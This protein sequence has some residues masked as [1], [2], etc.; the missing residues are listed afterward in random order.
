MK[1]LFIH[2]SCLYL[3]ASL[4]FG[5]ASQSN[6]QGGPRDVDPPQILSEKS[7]PNYQTQFNQRSI[8][9]QFNEFIKLQEPQNQIVVTPPL[10]YPPKLDII[11]K[12]LILRLH[13][14]EVLREETTY[15]IQL[16]KA[17]QDITESNTAENITWVFST[18]ATLDS[19]VLIGE[20][21]EYESDK[22]IAGALVMLYDQMAD[23]A[24]YLNKPLYFTY[25]D[26][27][28][29]YS[30][31][32]LKSG[33]YQM[34]ALKEEKP[35]Y[36]YDQPGE[37]IGFQANT[38]MVSEDS[39]SL[40]TIYM[41]QEVL[42]PKIQD[43]DSTQ[44]GTLV[45]RFDKEIEGTVVQFTDNPTQ[46]SFEAEGNQLTIWH[47][48]DTLLKTSVK[49]TQNN[50]KSDSL[51]ISSYP[52]ESTMR[53]KD[54][55]LSIPPSKKN[56]HPDSTA[57]IRFS[58]PIESIDVSKWEIMD[59][60]NNSNV[61][62]LQ[63]S[64]VIALDQSMRFF[65][66]P[67]LPSGEYSLQLRPGG[68]IDRFGMPNEQPIILV[69]SIMPLRDFV[70]ME[71]TLDSLDPEKNYMFRLLAENR[72]I[73]QWNSEGQSQ[74]IKTYPSIAIGKYQLEYWLDNN[75]NQRWDGGNYLKKKYPERKWT[76]PLEPL[77]P[78]WDSKQRLVIPSIQRILQD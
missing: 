3:F 78:D 38:I 29:K 28:G 60:K 69:F 8:T 22:P 57:L 43:V 58:A 55:S 37:W 36:R 68:V 54:P 72:V 23:S 51:R 32:H 40:P 44:K 27:L 39:A 45:V 77:R 33:I 9:L 76:L 12:K 59:K 16:G 50:G 47:S 20:V 71:I 52:L 14:K 13:E 75:K 61:I 74:N 67:V 30:L 64:D 31:R 56:I 6:I 66:L 4:F 1:R 65:Q 7:T 34:A 63:Q 5:C 24:I 46:T 25:T 42:E 15:T 62:A 70:F 49:I 18:G 73:D 26:S 19:L 11:G 21:K 2:L 41:F 35:S 53:R 48:N 10:S 17:I